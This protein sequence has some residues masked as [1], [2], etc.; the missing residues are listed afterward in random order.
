MPVLGFKVN[1][2][3]HLAR[4]IHALRWASTTQWPFNGVLMAL[5][6]WY[7]GYVRGYSRGP[8][9]GG[10]RLRVKSG[11]IDLEGCRISSDGLHPYLWLP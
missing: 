11:F 5:K 1:W 6:N 2:T 3:P 9:R 10:R 4:R 7:L 8:C